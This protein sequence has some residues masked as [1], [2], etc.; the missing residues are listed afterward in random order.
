MDRQAL[1]R[2]RRD[3]C[4][5]TG[6]QAGTAALSGRQQCHRRL[7]RFTNY[8]ATCFM[9]LYENFYFGTQ[10]GVV[11][12]AEKGGNDNGLPYH[13]TLV[14]GWEM[15]QQPSATVVWHQARAVFISNEA[16]VPHLSATTDFEIVIPTPPPVVADV[17][18]SDDAWDQ[19]KW[20]DARGI[21]K[22]RTSRSRGA[23]RCGYR[24]A[25]PGLPT[26]R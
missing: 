15:F 23:T 16:F 2:V 12:Q 24:S 17:G 22:C 1:G 5:H 14:G 21:R 4:H 10:D 19:G 9:R 7:G 6:R 18:L 11:M 13:A 3:L 8:D 25:R 20:D 26:P